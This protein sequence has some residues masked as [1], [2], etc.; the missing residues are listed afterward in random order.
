ML[1]DEH[2]CPWWLGYFFDN[3]LRRLFHKP[4]ALF[5]PYLGPGMTAVDIGCGMGFS[6]IA[7]A[8]IVGAAGRVIAADLQPQMLSIVH[9][10]ATKAGVAD[11]I[12]LHQCLSDRLGITATADFALTFWMAHEVPHL[13]AF[14]EEIH[15]LLKPGGS[16]LLVEPAVH[17]GARRFEEISG[18]A[19]QAGFVPAARPEIA[20]SRAVAFE[21]PGIIHS[22]AAHHTDR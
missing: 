19:L 15:S 22:A 18:H 14:M 16:Y 13:E 11:R 1:F 4:D 8:A 2:V 10:R 5:R 17:V 9:R 21:K 7:M 12:E 6:T 20:F 3:P